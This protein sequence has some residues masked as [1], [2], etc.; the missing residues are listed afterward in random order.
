MPYTGVLKNESG[1]RKDC[2][3]ET[4]NPWLLRANTATNLDGNSVQ[5]ESNAIIGFITDGS[6]GMGS[7]GQTAWEFFLSDVILKRC[8]AEHS[9]PKDTNSGQTK[10]AV[11]FFHSSGDP[12]TR[13]WFV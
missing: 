1:H 9:D 7:L 3:T 6:R 5:V 12:V 10:C 8:A 13:C 11:L 2:I 4:L